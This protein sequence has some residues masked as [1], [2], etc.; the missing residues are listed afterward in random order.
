MAWVAESDVKN[1]LKS[2]K[3]FDDNLIGAL[4]AY[5]EAL[6]K[7]KTNYTVDSAS[8]T[9][10]INVVETKRIPLTLT[11][12]TAVSSVTVYF[13]D[14]STV[15]DSDDYKVYTSGIL[16]FDYRISGE[17]VIKYTGGYSTVPDDIKKP[18]AL[19]VADWISKK[20]RLGI[21]SKS[22]ANSNVQYAD[23]PVLPVFQEAI[24]SFKN[25]IPDRSVV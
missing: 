8:K 12:V 22:L 3:D 19:Q 18:I 23:L 24:D 6:F 10:K 1:I 17:V 21:S 4:I 5:V 9:E 14:Y 2:S 15:I 13:E 7:Q 20:D 16:E 25:P 11:P